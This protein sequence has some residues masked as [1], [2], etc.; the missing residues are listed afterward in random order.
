ML[1]KQIWANFQR[2]LELFTQKIDTK[3][4]KN[5]GV[6]SG[7]RDP[8]SRKKPIPDPRIQGSKR[9]RIRIRN[10]DYQYRLISFFLKITVHGYPQLWP[11]RF[12]SNFYRP[13][14]PFMLKCLVSTMVLNKVYTYNF[15]EIWF[16]NI[17]TF[18]GFAK[19]FSHSRACSELQSKEQWS[20][21]VLWIWIRSEPKLL[22]GSGKKN[23]SVPVF[24]VLLPF[25]SIFQIAVFLTFLFLGSWD[26]VRRGGRWRAWI[27][28]GEMKMF[29]LGANL[30]INSDVYWLIL[31]FLYFW[32]LLYSVLY[33]KKSH[34]WCVNQ[35]FGSEF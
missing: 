23:H 28:R 11:F 15:I 13:N 19:K 16:L 33:S 5:M 14:D 25:T 10:T 4:S 7:I 18:F 24:T 21:A 29:S 20:H 30:E 32:T 26:R 9:P 1:K 3:L 6:G 2:I 12:Y 27:C 31:G 22:A 35:C 8:G 17:G 34:Y